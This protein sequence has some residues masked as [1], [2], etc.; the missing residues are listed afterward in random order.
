[1]M[2]MIKNSNSILGLQYHHMNQVR[3]AMKQVPLP[4]DVLKNKRLMAMHE[5]VLEAS[6]HC[7]EG[8]GVSG[9]TC[10]IVRELKEIE[11]VIEYVDQYTNE[12]TLFDLV[13]KEFFKKPIW[14]LLKFG[15]VDNR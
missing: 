7:V 6:I 5:A 8:C 9:R 1:M 3:E 15:D 2:M 12:I 13:K 4:Q 10:I 14:S 11:P